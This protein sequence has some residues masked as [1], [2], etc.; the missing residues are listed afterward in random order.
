MTKL[1]TTSELAHHLKVTTQTLYNWRKEGMPKT[2]VGSQYRYDLD[3]VIEW[4]KNK[5]GDN[6]N[7]KENN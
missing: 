2:K 6:D 5:N 3:E 1:L 7:A 4:L